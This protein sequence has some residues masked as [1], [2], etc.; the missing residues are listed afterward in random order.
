MAGWPCIKDS[1]ISR[2]S[3][4]CPVRS[5]DPV[6]SCTLFPCYTVIGAPPARTDFAENSHFPPTPCQPLPDRFRMTSGDFRITCGSLPETCGEFRK[7]S[8]PESSRLAAERVLTL[9]QVFHRSA[10]LC[11]HK[12]STRTDPFGASA[13]SPRRPSPRRPP[14]AREPKEHTGSP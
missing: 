8:A 1:Q 14:Q 10:Q 3:K 11:K 12:K 4:R 13:R 5:C 7:S 2:R 9:T 6:R